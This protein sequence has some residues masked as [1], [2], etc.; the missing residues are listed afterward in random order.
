MKTLRILLVTSLVLIAIFG[1]EKSPVKSETDQIPDVQPN[2]LG[3]QTVNSVLPSAMDTT[4]GT[5]EQTRQGGVYA[6]IVRD[7]IFTNPFIGIPLLSTL[8]APVQHPRPGTWVWEKQ[9]F[10]AT[11][12]L[13]GK[14][15]GTG[16]YN[17]TY[18]W[19]GGNFQD[20]VALEGHTDIPGLNGD[21]TMYYHDATHSRYGTKTWSVSQDTTLT[22][23]WE[24]AK[25]D[26]LNVPKREYL[27]H[28]RADKSGDLTFWEND[29]KR[30]YI[31]WY[32]DG[33]GFWDLWTAQG[34]HI[35][36][37]F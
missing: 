28:F 13:T 18:V 23:H 15:D 31:E 4:G 33:S 14:W 16:G 24:R 12:T 27:A 36:G 26:P 9:I 10:Q 5:S 6:Y 2:L 19:D 29:V 1:C 25:Y 20:F 21:Y 17:W 37:T 3:Y 34:N 7:I 11:H 22:I 8:Q 35:H 32:S 30:F